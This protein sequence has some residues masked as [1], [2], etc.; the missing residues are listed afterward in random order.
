[1]LKSKLHNP[2]IA[3]NS[4][5][6]N[7]VV[8]KVTNEN[9]L[10]FANLNSVTPVV[11]ETGR[12]W[13]NTDKGQFHFANISK[14]DGDKNF[15]DTFLSRTDT[16]NQDVVSKMDFQNTLKVNALDSKNILTI[17]SS[18][19]SV[20]IDGSTFS[21]KLTG[22]DENIIEGNSTVTVTG[23]VTETFK[24]DKKVDITGNVNE[25]IG[26]TSDLTVSGATTETYLSTFAKNVTG[27]VVE[28]TG[29]TVT[30]SVSGNVTENFSADVQTNV[31]S[32][33]GLKVGTNVTL[34][35]GSNNVKIL[36]N[37]S[38]N[39][40]AV[41]YANI[42]VTGQTETHTLS[43]KFIVN[44]G[45]TDKL[46]IDN[47]G[48]KITA[49]YNAIETTTS[50]ITANV[51]SFIA[52][53]DGVNDKII[54]NNADDD[55]AIRY[56]EVTITG[57]TTVDGNMLITGDLTIGG[58]TTKVDVKA[59]NLRIADNVIVLN[60]NLTMTDDPRLASAIVEGT[61]VDHN[62]GISV[63]RGS[64]GALDLIKWIESSD[65]A[66]NETLKQ[67]VAMTSIWNYESATPS[68]EL[69]QIIDAYTLARKTKNKS[70]TSWVGYDGYEGTN[71][72]TSVAA[73]AQPADA[74]DYSYKLDA[75]MLDTTI[76]SV[77][78]EIDTI[79]FD[80]YNTKR[81]GETPSAGTEFTITHN[82]GTVFVQV[83]TQRE[84]AGKWFF[85]IMP[86]Q[87]IDQNTIKIGASEP[88]KIR[89]MITAVE[90]FDINQ[91][92]DLVIV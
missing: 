7:A 63:N 3:K 71:Y 50:K 31:A 76:D 14:G 55:L 37:H 29:G 62:A 5:L 78:Q 65:T 86:V 45:V 85:D 58:Q 90:G 47:S 51:S 61:D 64:E 19:K 16:R 26:G 2:I 88:T 30:I 60:S 40:L 57:N 54:A 87:V 11:P 9:E 53:T 69:H 84:D 34:T 89:Y 72:T 70:G 24:N 48:N 46:I 41:N 43:N 15:V 74:L 17:D 59:E 68:Y 8:Q 77:A 73:G 22:N 6:E 13:F 10:E 80:K 23:K 20:K 27:N 42:G 12:I 38:T 49:N 35:D 52:I 18:D 44:D 81:V 82:L 91:A 83:I 28:V 67:A 39:S 33:L 25:S 1:M 56:A 32:N 36:A 4:Q 21:K 92:T 79:K 75:A 66:S